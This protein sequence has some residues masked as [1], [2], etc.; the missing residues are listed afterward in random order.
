MTPEDQERQ[1]NYIKYTSKMG[2]AMVL[3][4]ASL[5]KV[6]GMWRILVS[7]TNE[8]QEAYSWWDLFIIS[9]SLILTAWLLSLVLNKSN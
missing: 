5:N 8:T 4:W 7:S 2:C 1:S 9:W 3:I 6:L